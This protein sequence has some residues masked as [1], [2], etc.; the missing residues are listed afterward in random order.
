MTTVESNHLTHFTSILAIL[1]KDTRV[2]VSCYMSH[3]LFETQI[4]ISL[5]PIKVTNTNYD[6]WD[7]VYFIIKRFRAISHIQQE[8]EQKVSQPTTTAGSRFQCQ[9]FTVQKAFRL[10]PSHHSRTT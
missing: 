8:L 4:P 6:H 10:F 1:N 9:I 5:V 3:F 7:L 2:L